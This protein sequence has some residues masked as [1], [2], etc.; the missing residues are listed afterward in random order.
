MQSIAS[1]LM[2]ICRAST[3]RESTTPTK[4]R[5]VS[6]RAKAIPQR[7]VHLEVDNLMAG[8]FEKLQQAQGKVEQE[9]LH[10]NTLT[11]PSNLHDE[12]FSS[13]HQMVRG[14]AGGVQ[15]NSC[16]RVDG[17][18]SLGSVRATALVCTWLVTWT[19]REA[20]G[21]EAR[22]SLARS[23]VIRHSGVYFMVTAGGRKRR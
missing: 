17:C 19:L 15:T 9:L 16:A 10:S 18:R 8:F 6:A 20:D 1:T 11:L 5:E 23:L 2:T 7:V 12:F 13:W 4:A 3:Q 21:L 14:Q 22:R